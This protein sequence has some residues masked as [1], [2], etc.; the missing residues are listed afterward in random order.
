MPR[1]ASYDIG[2]ELIEGYRLVDFLGK[3][4]FGEV[5]KARETGT[6]KLVAL[7][8]IDLTHSASALKELRALNMVKNLNHPNL[9]PIFTARLKDKSNRDIPL[10]ED[11]KIEE[12]KKKGQLKALV[13]AMG[14]GEK[15]LSGRL[16]ELNPIGQGDPDNPRGIPTDELLNYMNGAAKGIDYLN[17]VNHG[18][19]ENDGPIVHCD[20]KPE[21]MMIVSGEVQIADCGVAVII[22][23][24]IRQTQAAG[25]PAYSPPELTINKPVPGSDQYSL[26]IS[27]YE[28]RTGGF[29]PFDESIGAGGI[30]IAH[31]T[32]ALD[33][34]KGRM[35]DSE[36]QVLRWATAVM[37]IHRYPSCLDMVKQLD[38]AIQGMPIRSPEQIRATQSNAGTGS[39][40]DP[41]INLSGINSAASIGSM[42]IS[43]ASTIRTPASS[44]TMNPL[45]DLKGT[46]IPNADTFGNMPMVSQGNVDIFRGQPGAYDPYTST[47]KSSGGLT[48]TRNDVS[49]D[50]YPSS[51]RKSK[52]SAP[53]TPHAIE[54][55]DDTDEKSG[56]SIG[57]VAAGIV[58]VGVLG[59]A[60]F[61][62]LNKSKTEPSG[63]SEVAGGT[64]GTGTTPETKA[65]DKAAGTVT[66]QTNK[67]VV[68]GGS[69][70]N[71]AVADMKLGQYLNDGEFA[72]AKTYIDTQADAPQDVAA[73]DAWVQTAYQRV[74]TAQWNSRITTLKGKPAG[75]FGRELV[76]IIDPLKPEQKTSL[77][78][79]LFAWPQLGA[80]R[81]ADLRRVLDTDKYFDSLST[82]HKARLADWLVADLDTK[83]KSVEKAMAELAEPTI[84]EKQLPTIRSAVDPYLEALNTKTESTWKAT[85]KPAKLAEH[86]ARQP[87]L[88]IWSQVRNPVRTATAE[89]LM[90]VLNTTTMPELAAI[91]M[92][93][94]LRL[95]PATPGEA[96]L[97]RML[98][99]RNSSKDWPGAQTQRTTLQAD[100]KTRYAKFID[101]ELLKSSPDL[102]A[103]RALAT[104]DP[105]HPALP[106]VSILDHLNKKE[107]TEAKAEL[108]K[109][110]PAASLKLSA[111]TLTDLKT[112]AGWEFT[113]EELREAVTQKDRLP[114]TTIDTLVERE[115]AEYRAAISP[116]PLGLAESDFAAN[117]F[118]NVDAKLKAQ[119]G[120]RLKELAQLKSGASRQ[121][122][123]MDATLLG[124]PAPGGPTLTEMSRIT[125]A[126]VPKAL[127]YFSTIAQSQNNPDDYA[128]AARLGQRFQILGYATCDDVA[129]VKIR[130]Q[131]IITKIAELITAAPAGKGKSKAQAILSATKLSGQIIRN[132][133]KTREQR[134]DAVETLTRNAQDLADDDLKSLRAEALA[135]AGICLFLRF[136]DVN[137]LNKADADG[138][139]NAW[140]Q[141]RDLANQAIALDPQGYN[142]YYLKSLIAFTECKAIVLQGVPKK[143]QPEGE[144][145]IEALKAT[146]KTSDAVIARLGDRKVPNFW[147][148]RMKA[149]LLYCEL[150]KSNLTDAQMTD[151][152]DLTKKARDTTI[153]HGKDITAQL[154]SINKKIEDLTPKP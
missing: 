50:D 51:I 8:S 88:T 103:I 116:A 35:T 152:L 28:L 120:P 134:I 47:P 26:A 57:R 74:E 13:I 49:G 15:S 20:I 41:G 154:D 144:A 25:S 115:L 97:K 133:V 110:K 95:Q 14:L 108:Q 10:T 55:D 34:R 148:Y 129:A 58:L 89:P 53:I 106:M 77:L 127:A 91:M 146:I 113:V 30:M 132:E 9:V 112:R 22:T 59:A 52:T 18:A 145:R 29:L 94:F 12:L 54:T 44:P 151:A 118:A 43:S 101:N 143:F 141:L 69:R 36:R 122:L 16:E 72:K 82:E 42:G 4:Q 45:S 63:K 70:F 1:S 121:D 147:D 125:D 90:A 60:G 40:H 131:A 114:T 124:T 81:Q 84:N 62:A 33:F 19:G 135:D 75:E 87:I 86:E 17:K 128:A 100:L 76:T 93:E 136:I 32:G 130:D 138:A 99:L 27:Y 98:E 107:L 5:W 11:A 85:P 92:G 142:G 102:M 123:A 140:T 111:G 109:W 96:D 80:A 119:W 150:D 149:F 37:P 104:I 61:F 21:N 139:E 7:K 31:A 48:S 65:T 79:E 24:D 3:G 6:G 38:Y 68:G 66:P 153:K 23:P 78:K 126:R 73:P 71:I 2:E 46:M 105:D 117:P 67:M 56:L 137:D 83:Y 39:G 64:Q